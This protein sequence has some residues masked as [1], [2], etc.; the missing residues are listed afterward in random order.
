MFCNCKA[1]NSLLLLPCLA[2]L[3]RPREFRLRIV[4]PGLGLTEFSCGVG[5]SR[6]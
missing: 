5:V 2:V 3:S 4:R 6:S 1:D